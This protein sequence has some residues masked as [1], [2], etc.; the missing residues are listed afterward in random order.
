MAR[1]LALA[2]FGPSVDRRGHV[3]GHVREQSSASPSKLAAPRRE[4][5]TPGGSKSLASS[6]GPWPLEVPSRALPA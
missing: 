2:H 1:W 3:F 4:F 6:Q 5:E